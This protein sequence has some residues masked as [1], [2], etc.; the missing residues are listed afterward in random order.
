MP[1]DP[2]TIENT[3]AAPAEVASPELAKAIG[4]IPGW[5]VAWLIQPTW[6]LKGVVLKTLLLVVGAVGYRLISGELERE[7]KCEVT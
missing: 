7:T 6:W 2:S 4:P 5:A 1:I 3:S